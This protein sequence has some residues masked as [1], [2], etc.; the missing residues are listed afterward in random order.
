MVARPAEEASPIRY[1]ELDAVERIVGA[2]PTLQ[3]RA[4]LAFQYGAAVEV[5]V[6]LGLTRGD[7]D[8]ARREVRAAGTKAITR[9]RLVRVADWA[10]PVVWE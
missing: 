9:D 3:R 1:Y 7:F 10:W 8:P 6:T 5:S 4:L 2:Q